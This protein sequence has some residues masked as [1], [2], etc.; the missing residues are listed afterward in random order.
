[1]GCGR[2][3]Q[4]FNC[5]DVEIRPRPPNTTLYDSTKL[6]VHEPLFII[7]PNLN[8]TGIEIFQRAIEAF[9]DVR[10]GVGF[11]FNF[12]QPGES[13]SPV[14]TQPTQADTLGLGRMTLNDI[15]YNTHPGQQPIGRMPKIKGINVE[16]DITWP[17]SPVFPGQA[18]PP[19]VIP[20][21]EQP[22][23]PISLAPDTRQPS[24]SRPLQPD[25]Q[26]LGIPIPIETGRY[27][28]LRNISPRENGRGASSMTIPIFDAFSTQRVRTTPPPKEPC[29]PRSANFVCRG[30]GQYLNT[31]GIDK[32][33]LR[34]CRQG[35]CAYKFMCD[36]G[37]GRMERDR[38]CHAIGTFGSIPGM[39][40]W[41]T[42]V[43]S[44]TSCPSNVCNVSKCLSHDAS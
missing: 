40:E 36:C 21:A 28:V 44:G 1:M 30:K 43:C 32:W 33:C 37:C 4:F 15:L 27:N 29:T 18:T 2:Q 35:N 41:C 13:A 7:P 16:P 11:P 22:P 23:P 25:I 14:G 34:N 17:R 19:P 26:R 5:A 31:K 12:I 42:N 6:N 8:K 39:D 3:E 9:P 10:S 20:P 38:R 24:T